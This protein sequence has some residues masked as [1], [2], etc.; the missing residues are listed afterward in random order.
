MFTDQADTT[1]KNSMNYLKTFLPYLFGHSKGKSYS[2]PGDIDFLN[3][4]F[5]ESLLF[6]TLGHT[7]EKFLTT[8]SI[9]DLS[10]LQVF[11][12]FSFHEYLPTEFFVQLKHQNLSEWKLFVE[13]IATEGID[14]EDLQDLLNMENGKLTL[15]ALLH[16]DR[17]RTGKMLIRRPNGQFLLNASGH[18]WSIPIL[19]LSSRGLPFNHSNGETPQGI[20]T[21]DSV[22]PLADKNEEFGAFR[23]LIVNFIPKSDEEVKLKEYMPTSQYSLDW[24]KPGVVAREMGR[25]L[26]RIHGSGSST[27]ILK[28]Y[29]PMVPT[30]GCLATNEVNLFGLYQ[31][32]DQRNLLDALMLSL[33]LT[34]NFDNESKIHGLLYVVEF[35]GKFQALEFRH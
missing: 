20:F 23:R 6:H 17:T 33:D 1:T 12:L 32:R 11:H 25:S 14:R 19:G 10:S 24:W 8:L 4:S 5:E 31:S 9:K 35:D 27:N 2:L 29:Y 13:S 3:L 18:L 7:L 34:P 30:S 15:F 26:L 28:P 22:M 21:I 16:N